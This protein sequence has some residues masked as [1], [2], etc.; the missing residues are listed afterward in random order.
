MSN[1]P[2]FLRFILLLLDCNMK[3]WRIGQLNFDKLHAL[4]SS[5][6]SESL[7]ATFTAV[8]AVLE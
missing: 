2:G 4:N 1:F 6:K 5:C 8:L 3:Q 7:P